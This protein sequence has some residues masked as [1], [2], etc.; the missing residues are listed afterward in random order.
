M[1]TASQ[2]S[3][4]P[5]ELEALIALAL[6]EHQA[7]RLAEA[8]A[9]YRKIL[10]IR[11]DIAEAHNNLANV[12]L[13][14]GEPD[15]AV[16]HFEHAVTLRPDFA[17]AHNNLGFVLQWQGKLDQAARHYERALAFNSGLFQTHNNLGNILRD[18]GQLD[19]AVARYQQAVAINPDFAEAHFNIG[20]AYGCLGNLDAAAFHCQ[21]ALALRP[22]YVEAHFNLGNVL[23]GQGKLDAAAASYRQAL[24]LRPEYVE[25]HYNLGNLLKTQGMLD[26]AAAS[27]ER[28]ATLQPDFFPAHNNLGGILRDQG[29]LDQAAAQYRRAIALM[30][31]LVDAHYNLGNVLL[32]QSKLDEAAAC[33]RQALALK[34]DY[35]DAHMGLATCYLVQGDY[36]RGWPAYEGRLHIP[37]FIP[38]PSAAR[39]TGEPLAGRSLLLLAEQGV[40]DTIHFVRYARLLKERGARVVLAAQPALGRLLARN[41]DL[42][43]LTILGSA[44]G[45]PHTDFYLPLLSAPG[46]LGTDAVTIPNRVPYL[47]ADA[48]LTAKWG[49]ELAG[50]RGMKIAIAWQG[51]RGFR[52]DSQRSI[53]LSQFAPLARL[54]GVRLISLQKGFGSEQVATVDFPLLDLS[55]RLDEDAGP[56]MDTAAVIRSVDLVVTANTAIAHLAGALGTP[57][58]L[59]LHVSPDWRWQLGRDDSPWYPTMRIFRQA[60]I[61]Q[62][63]DVFER[64]ARALRARHSETEDHLL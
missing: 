46:A 57:V 4:E 28:A 22:D 3:S 64:M 53:P 19:Q 31:E 1:T 8:A 20:A 14:Q 26:E 39:W 40:G 32:D 23:Q 16:A 2:T 55:D 38:R 34:P 54:P 18:Q 30:P 17:E 25:A 5:G 7:G 15:E 44:D 49:R 11:P 43:E 47:A 50:L 63:A 59:A 29:K 60:S 52:L 9:T 27:Y 58:W 33:Y 41:P 42:D 24:A 10:A 62:W 12:L 6:G 21:R 45:L 13:G 36:E 37:G 51:A 35:G 48:Q 61:G 56:F